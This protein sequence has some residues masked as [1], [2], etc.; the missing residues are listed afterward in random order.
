[1]VA[2]FH[3][4]STSREGL[5]GDMPRISLVPALTDRAVHKVADLSAHIWKEYWTPL[6]GEELVAHAL[7]TTQSFDSIR[8]DTKSGMRPHWLVLNEAGDTIGY[9]ASRVDHEKGTLEV[10]KVYLLE[11]YRGMHYASEIL[12]FHESTCRANGLARMELLV[13]RRNELGIRAYSGRG[14]RIEREVVSNLGS[15]HTTLDYAMVKDVGID[16]Q[17][18]RRLLST[19]YEVQALH[20]GDTMKVLLVN[21]G[22]HKNG[23]TDRALR[24]VAKT[25]EEHGVD[26]EIFWTGTKPVTGCMGCGACKKLGKCVVDDVVNEFQ[27]KA[28]EADGFVFGAPVHYAHAAASL[29]GFMDRLF[30]SNSRAEINALS[31]K[32]AAAIA[33]AR[34]AG[35]TSAL[36]DIEKFFG[37]TQMPVVSSRYWNMV[38]G[39][40]AEEVEQDEEGL[41]GM[42]QLGR[43]MAW[44]IASIEAGKTAGLELPEQETGT[45]TNFIR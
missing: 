18:E 35:T 15:G 33:S 26:A 24:E 21:G 45:M 40:T 41:W 1:M 4:V 22:P 16:G 9:T 27:M 6:L 32:P 39:N 37:I 14:W 30:Y 12:D 7:R 38:H 8:R 44:L 19:D 23:C 25:L 42:R 28:R 17:N 29:L 36:D 34:R 11:G 5:S 43:N 3:G 10:A 31:H 2:H 20:K 13:N